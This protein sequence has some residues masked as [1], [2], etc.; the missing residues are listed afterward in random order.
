MAGGFEWA[1]RGLP[2]SI[3]AN[4]TAMSVVD[5][6]SSSLCSLSEKTAILLRSVTTLV[7]WSVLKW[8]GSLSFVSKAGMQV[9][10][11]R[12]GLFQL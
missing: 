5:I 10:T 7:S 12:I 6:S 9:E 1:L 4:K 8:G 2:L 3:S 11:V